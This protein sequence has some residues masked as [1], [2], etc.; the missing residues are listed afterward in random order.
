VNSVLS[1]VKNPR[2]RNPRGPAPHEQAAGRARGRR[3]VTFPLFGK[4]DVNE[5]KAAP[6]FA[7]L[8]SPQATVADKGPVKWNFEKFLIGRDGQPVGRY[9]SKVSPDDPDLVAA[10]EAALGK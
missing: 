6:L 9:R 7:V 2:S 8:T 1:V 4:V 5:E 10:I 3:E